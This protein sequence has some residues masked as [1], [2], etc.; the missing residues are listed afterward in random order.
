MP[1]KTRRSRQALVEDGRIILAIDA[2]KNGKIPSVR[3]AA[4]IYQIPRTTLRN[5]LDGY[6]P[7]TE[8]RTNSHKLS[9]TEEESLVQWIL[10][11]DK[12]GP[13]PRPAEV[14]EIV[15]ILR[16]LLWPSRTNMRYFPFVSLSVNGINSF[17]SY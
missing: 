15:N 8:Q 16:S 6:I 14:E 7:C 4:Y 12:R 9:P 11:R 2:I 17:S 3:Q 13:P 5:R 1:P 10:S